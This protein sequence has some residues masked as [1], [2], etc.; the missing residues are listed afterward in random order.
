MEER[1]GRERWQTKCV[2]VCVHLFIPPFIA[3]SFSPFSLCENND[4]E[5]PFSPQGGADDGEG[6]VV[7][8]GQRNKWALYL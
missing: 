8:V 1:K 5:I 3:C 6:A 2:C 4:G 7:V